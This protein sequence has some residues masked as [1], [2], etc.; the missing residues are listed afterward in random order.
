MTTRDGKTKALITARY[1]GNT[2]VAQYA[3]MAF[4]RENFGMKGKNLICQ[5]WI[6]FFGCIAIWLIGRP[7]AWGRWGYV[8]GI[9]AQ[10]AW[11]YT[12][13]KNRQWGIAVLSFWYTYSWGQGIWFHFIAN[14]W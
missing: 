8:F 6:M 1:V 9:I 7:E 12:S 2:F 3:A 5:I 4:N 10:P 11:I 13:V 14:R